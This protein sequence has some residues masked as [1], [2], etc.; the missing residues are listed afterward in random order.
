MARKCLE[1]YNLLQLVL[2]DTNETPSLFSLCR[3]AKCMGRKCLEECNLPLVSAPSGC[4]GI[5]NTLEDAIGNMVS[6]RFHAT[7]T[8]T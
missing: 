5:E 8:N 2:D 6:C 3:H 7:A 4:L 1:D